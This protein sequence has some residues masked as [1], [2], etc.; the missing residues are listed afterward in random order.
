MVFEGGRK[1]A[2]GIDSN[3]EQNTSLPKR[4]KNGKTGRIQDKNSTT[5][6]T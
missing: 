4:M 1:F 3:A 6:L 2:H 5:I